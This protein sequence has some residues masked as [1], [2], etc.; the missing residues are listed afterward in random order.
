MFSK[1]NIGNYNFLN[2]YPVFVIFVPFCMEYL[3]S[4]LSNSIMFTCFWTRFM[5]STMYVILL[6][7]TIYYPEQSSLG[8]YTHYPSQLLLARF[9]PMTIKT[10]TINSRTRTAHDIPSNSSMDFFLDNDLI[11]QLPHMI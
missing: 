7:S 8:H 1:K 9:L 3:F 11:G 2:S 4:F 5:I 10:W 6:Y